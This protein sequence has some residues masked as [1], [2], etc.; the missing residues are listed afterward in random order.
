MSYYEGANTPKISIRNNKVYYCGRLATRVHD[1]GNYYLYH[2]ELKNIF[3]GM[4]KCDFK[5]KIENSENEIVITPKK[6]KQGKNTKGYI[7]TTEGKFLFTIGAKQFEILK[8]IYQV[9]KLEV[10]NK[11]ED[12]LIRQIKLKFDQ[13]F[14]QKIFNYGHNNQ[15]KYVIPNKAN[16]KLRLDTKKRNS[17]I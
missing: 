16:F 11:N 3:F 4:Q 15:V 6:S 10:K 8:E 14:I 13:I 7:V 5:E 9:D 1:Y 12:N 2:D 17:I